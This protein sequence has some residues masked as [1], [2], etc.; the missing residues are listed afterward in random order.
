VSKNFFMSALYFF[1]LVYLCIG[2]A[3]LAH[4]VG[5]RLFPQ[6]PPLHTFDNCLYF[7]YDIDGRVVHLPG[8]G[9]G[10]FEFKSSDQ[11]CGE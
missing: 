9:R 11:E 7:Y 10:T 4:E 8:K 5:D 3:F 6:K 1:V 2:A